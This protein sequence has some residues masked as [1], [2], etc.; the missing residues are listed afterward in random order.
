MNADEYAA[1]A[2]KLVAVRGD[3]D[4]TADY[5]RHMRAQTALSMARDQRLTDVAR[6]L[7]EAT[8]RLE[9]IAALLAT[10]TPGPWARLRNYLGRTA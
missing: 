10:P 1:A 3:D 5:L 2:R 4:N 9:D 8:E 6:Q 7:T